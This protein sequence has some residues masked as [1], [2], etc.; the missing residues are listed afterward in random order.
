MKKV[1]LYPLMFLVA[2]VSLYSLSKNDNNISRKYSF[3]EI[4]DSKA[5]AGAKGAQEYAELIYKDV[6]TGK[7]E[8]AKLAAAKDQVL[9]RMQSRSTNFN[10]VEEGPDNVGGRTRGIAIHPNDDNVMYAGS[11]S[12]GLFKTDNGGSNW[13]RVQEFDNT[14][15]NSAGGVG[16]LGISSIAFSKN[17]NIL[18][19]ATGGSRFGEGLIDGDGVWVSS[20]INTSSPTFSQIPGTDNK[21][22]LKVVINPNDPNGAY[23]VGMNVG[24]NKIEQGINSVF[25]SNTISGIP[26]NATIGD[27]KVSEDGQVM[28]LGLDQ[29]GIRS[30]ISQDGGANWTSLHA[31]GQLS[32]IGTIRGEYAISKNKNDNS[33][34]TLYA[35]FAASN[36]TLGGVYR[37]VDNGTIWHQIAP[38]A[39]GNFTPLTSRN[40]Q[41]NYDLVVTSRPDGEECIIGG[42]DLWSWVHTPNSTDPENGQWYAVSAWYVDPSVPIYIHADKAC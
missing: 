22:I 20:D 41:G 23:Y 29:G 37:S 17:G 1:A 35:L 27:L 24:L 36:G 4:S 3:K 8:L 28:I 11:V 38:G 42:I 18:Y 12:G 26:T 30:W 15:V 25:E 7:V 6:V 10:F 21:D 16:S 33:F 34:Y 9:Q 32:G 31:N 40:G 39:T 19:V 5:F 13:T 2:V 14:M